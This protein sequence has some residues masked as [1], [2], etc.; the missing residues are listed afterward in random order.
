MLHASEAV[1][2]P[3]PLPPSGT[4]RSAVPRD[5]D[6]AI[7]TIGGEIAAVAS[8]VD[9]LLAAVIGI[10]FAGQLRGNWPLITLVVGRSSIF[11]PCP[12]AR[13]APGMA[14]CCQA[15]GCSWT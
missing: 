2:V 6:K 14:T 1:T 15:G 11:L 12:P 8:L 9:Y 13:P 4:A 3:A 5:Q 7:A 10:F